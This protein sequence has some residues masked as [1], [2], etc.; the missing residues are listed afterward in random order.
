MLE[1]VG[2]YYGTHHGTDYHL[3]FT[4]QTVMRHNSDCAF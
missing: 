2:Q 4:S 3:S 1:Y